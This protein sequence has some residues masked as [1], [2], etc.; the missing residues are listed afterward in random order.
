[1]QP[2]QMTTADFA[3]SIRTKYPTGKS[4]DGRMY[5]EIPDRELAQKIV[6]KYPV[7]QSR[8]SDFTPEQQNQANTK[9]A[10]GEAVNK[11]K[12]SYGEATAASADPNMGIMSKIGKQL[13]G[14]LGIASGLYSAAQAPI[15]GVI[16]TVS[17]AVSDNP[18]VQKATNSPVVAPVLDFANKLKAPLDQVAQTHPEVAK[19]IGD[20]LNVFLSTMAATEIPGVVKNA[21]EVFTQGA[22][23]TT[24]IPGE[25]KTAVT[26][27]MAST[28][29]AVS[30]KIGGK[31]PQ[32]ILATPET[33]VYKLS[34]PE[35]EYY[36]KNQK[37]TLAKSHADV[38]AKVKQELKT[39]TEASQ[40]QI[41]D[42]NKEVEQTAYNKTVKLKPKA[43][44]VFGEQSKVY[45]S[46]VDEEIA[47]HADVKISQA[48]LK[49][50]IESKYADNPELGKSMVNKLGIT[51]EAKPGFPN[52]DTNIGDIYQKTKSLKQD[53]G[54]GAK[55]GNRVYTAEE[56][57]TDDAIS[58]LSDFMKSKGVDLSEAN[59]F[60]REWA[61]LRDK[62]ITKLKPF[63]AG[64]F[65]TKTFSK[66]LTDT[67]KG[68]IHNQ[69]FIKAF[70]D[71]LGEPITKETKAAF[72][73][74]TDAQKTKLANELDAEMKI[75]ENKLAQEKATKSLTDSQFEVERLA[76]RKQTIRRILKGAGL[77]IGYEQARK[78]LPILP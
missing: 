66:I 22:K 48:E 23:A 37:E 20:L 36:M 31:T 73:K 5:S 25:I 13:E 18:T 17:D 38:E 1:M 54:T 7:Y 65:E 67:A 30:T 3:N 11:I 52:S 24:K 29:Q 57:F 49:Q 19:N 71:A 16:K 58:T 43:V 76:R 51:D 44:K 63:D 2:Q 41:E 70:E 10:F 55:K 15:S 26:D 6:T 59:K 53:I 27:K 78:Y 72:E 62:I 69:S 39:K 75:A 34:Q 74:L 35:R 77:L 50:F 14:G 45:R 56:K 60:W 68:D 32:E 21:S 47:Q 4:S 9:A 28:K 8:L 46:L 64:G 33:D 42:L 40:K 61:P 12:S